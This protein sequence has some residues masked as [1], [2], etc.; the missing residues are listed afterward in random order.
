VLIIAGPVYIDPNGR[1]QFVEGHREIVEQARIYPGCLDL[2]ITCD[3]VDPGRVNIFEMWESEEQLDTWRG[4]APRPTG[5][6]PA[7]VRDE[8]EKH[9]VSASGP[10]F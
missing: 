3:T 5:S 10:P 2:A 7:I 4:V 6:M 1:D 9:Q 8:V